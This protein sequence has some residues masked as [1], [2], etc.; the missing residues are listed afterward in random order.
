MTRASSWAVLCIA[1]VPFAEV[2]AA[3]LSIPDSVIGRGASDSWGGG[4]G[5]FNMY[6]GD[7]TSSL[8]VRAGIV[9][10][11]PDL[12]G[13]QVNS[14]TLNLQFAGFI[15]SA[16]TETY[17]VRNVQSS[18]IPLMTGGHGLPTSATIHTDMGDGTLYGSTTFDAVNTPGGA[19]LSTTLSPA[20]LTDI[21]AASNSAFAF[22][23]QSI[24]RSGNPDG[25]RFSADSG[26]LHSLV[27]DVSP[28]GI[29]EPTSL[30]LLG[31]TAAGYCG[32]RIRRRRID[33]SL[34]TTQAV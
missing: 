32:V 24:T 19:I 13:L 29:P 9:F 4:P 30:A 10:Q 11:I 18:T 16:T 15:L 22:G 2:N 33:R 3:I 14:A 7:D 21:F 23:L 25:W 5:F 34:N 12:T 28:V 6:I 1:F 17:T 8:D 31:I 27:L 20:A 26:A